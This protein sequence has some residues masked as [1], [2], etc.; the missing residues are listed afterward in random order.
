MSRRP[1][2]RALGVTALL[3]LAMLLPL[4]AGAQSA[5]GSIEG[6]VVD[7]SGGVLPGVTVTVTESATGTER[8][9]ITEG[10]ERVAVLAVGAED[11]VGF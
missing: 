2:P 6:I 7:A 10:E 8:A 4:T 5:T 1:V 3:I 9:A 11:L